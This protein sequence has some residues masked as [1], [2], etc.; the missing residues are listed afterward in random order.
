M[1]ETSAPAP[2][3]APP[4]QKTKSTLTY[5]ERLE[6]ERIVERADAAERRVV[7]LDALLAD[8]TLYSQRGQDVAPLQAKLAS[9]KADRVGA[10]GAVGG[11]RGEEG[12]VSASVRLADAADYPAFVGLFPEL[13]VADPVPTPEQFASSMLPRVVV[14][15]EDG[16]VQGYAFWM[17]LRRESRTSCTW[18]SSRERAVAAWAARCSRR[19]ARGSS[20]SSAP[21][22]SST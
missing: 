5:A 14:F 2:P 1:R 20:R 15:E 4:A 13:A 8:P 19:F 7:E 11:P 21:A 16:R 17:P 6:L 10:R 3:P 12:V 22:G 18:W 9:A